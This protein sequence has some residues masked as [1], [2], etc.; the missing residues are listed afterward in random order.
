MVADLLIFLRNGLFYEDGYRM[1]FTAYFP[2]RWLQMKK[3]IKVEKGPSRFGEIGFD[4]EF[5]GEHQINLNLDIKWSEAPVDLEWH[6]PVRMKKAK[7]DGQEYA[8]DGHRIHFPVDAKK[9]EIFY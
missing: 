5:I 7:V 3:P 1:V 6:V 4:I 2:K 9:V 8:Y